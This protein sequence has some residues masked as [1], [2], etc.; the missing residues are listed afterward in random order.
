MHGSQIIE[1]WNCVAY[2]IKYQTV[3]NDY[4]LP[5]LFSG[6]YDLYYKIQAKDDDQKV[7][8]FSEETIIHN[9]QWESKK[10]ELI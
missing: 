4:G 1:N 3:Y 10:E 5:C 7:F 8:N 9:V 2:P 6:K